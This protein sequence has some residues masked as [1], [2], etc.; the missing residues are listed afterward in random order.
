MVKDIKNAGGNNFSRRDGFQTLKESF[1]DGE[2][3]FDQIVVNSIVPVR[4]TRLSY[5]LMTLLDGTDDVKYIFF[6]GHGETESNQIE[7][8]DKPL[9]STEKT[10]LDFT[11][12][13]A[14]D[15][16]STHFFMYDDA[17]SVGLWFNLDGGDSAPAIIV[18][19]FIEIP[20]VS[21]DTPIDLALATQTAIQADSEFTAV[22]SNGYVMVASSSNGNRTNSFDGDSGINITVTD[23]NSSINSKYISITDAKDNKFHVW[24]NVNSTGLDPDPDPGNSTGIEVPLDVA[25]TAITVSAKTTTILDTYANFLVNSE[26]QFMVVKNAHQGISDGIIDGDT[27]FIIDSVK[28]GEDKPLVYQ[29][30]FFYDDDSYPISW[31]PVNIN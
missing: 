22:N 28:A 3:A 4:Y 9:G 27:G 24:W 29:I 16:S 6:W 13:A 1:N 18:N 14:A 7:F 2:S 8:P 20:I 12:S 23:G 5:E 19:R 11:N 15:L 21:G 17:G 31:E 25:E 26:D 30:E 10:T